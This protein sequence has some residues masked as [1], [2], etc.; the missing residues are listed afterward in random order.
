P[1][2]NHCLT[3]P[4]PPHLAWDTVRA[5]ECPVH[6]GTTILGVERRHS[7]VIVY[8]ENGSIETFD[9]VVFA[10]GRVGCTD[11]LQLPHPDLLLDETQRVWSNEFGQTSLSHIYAVG[12][13]VGF[14][15]TSVS[16]KQQALRLV[17]HLIQ[18][19]T[20]TGHLVTPGL[21]KL[22]VS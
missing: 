12:S 2:R 9:G 18:E 5:L 16:P 14:P 19:D 20:P 1:P 13:V 11:H 3:N 10:V 17:E 22:L 7:S 21:G 8:H 15:K 4:S 6:W